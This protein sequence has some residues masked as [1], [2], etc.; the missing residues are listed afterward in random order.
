M[1]LLS[2]L[3][4][5]FFL[6]LQS[7]YTGIKRTS[8]LPFLP[9]LK[10][11]DVFIFAHDYQKSTNTFNNLYAIDFS[12]KEELNSLN[13]IKLAMGLSIPGKVRVVHFNTIHSLNFTEEW[14]EK[15]KYL[16]HSSDMFHIYPCIKL[17]ESRF[18]IYTHNCKHFSYYLQSNIKSKK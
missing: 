1:R 15:V 14:Y 6:L 4:S 12:P 5:S 11:H 16:E 17:W 2:I 13:I 18:N 8:I 7:F 3:S 10:L 9:Q